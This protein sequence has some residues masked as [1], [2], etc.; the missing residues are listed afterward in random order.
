MYDKVKELVQAKPLYFVGI[1]IVLVGVIIA[2][3]V[4]PSGRADSDYQHSIDTVERAQEQQRKSLD[5]NQGIQ[6]SVDQSID[7][8]RQ[9]GERIERI[10]EY[11]RATIQRVDESKKRLDDAEDLLER[12]EQIFRDVESRHQTEQSHGA[13][14]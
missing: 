6:N 14:P 8:N 9:S 3:M 13:T 4:S 12:N 7:L 1:G 10:E 11:Q 2:F 5:L